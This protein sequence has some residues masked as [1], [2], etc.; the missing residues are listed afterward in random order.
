MLRSD[1]WVSWIEGKIRCVWIHGVPGAGKT[2]LASHLIEAV[3]EL[4]EAESATPKYAYV[5]YY[6]YF[7]HNQNEAAPFLKWTLNQLC[8]QADMVPPHLHKL[9]KHG[10]E[11]SLVDLLRSLEAIVEA[12]DSIYLVL[13]AIDESTERA[14]LFTVVRDL[15]TDARFEKVHVI[16]TSREYIDIEKVMYGISAP[17]SMR[18]PLLDEDIKLYI[19]SQLHT[20]PR[21]SLWPSHL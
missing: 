3:E 7:G 12:F 15:A 20:H 10:G 11:P 14:E 18:N 4:C 6:C 9:Y 2:I 21:L 5:Y 1:E 13:D 17:V 16:A 19:Q 8:R